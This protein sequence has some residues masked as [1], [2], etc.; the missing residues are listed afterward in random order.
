M[1]KQALDLAK[2]RAAGATPPPDERRDAS[3][4]RTRKVSR[5]A[6]ANEIA[7]EARSIQTSPAL[8]PGAQPAPYLVAEILKNLAS[9]VAQLAERV[10]ELG[11]RR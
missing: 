8:H 5:M 10:E 7:H 3:K 4:S 6:T 11:A 2:D 9:L 1:R